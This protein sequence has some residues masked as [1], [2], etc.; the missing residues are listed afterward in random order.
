M[1]TFKFTWRR[2]NFEYIIL[3]LYVCSQINRFWF[4]HKCFPLDEHIT[5]IFNRIFH[6]LYCV[7]LQNIFDISFVL[8]IPCFSSSN[9]LIIVFLIYYMLGCSNTKV[10][11]FLRL[12]WLT[13]VT[14]AWNSLSPRKMT[15]KSFTVFWQILW[16]L[17]NASSHK[18][19]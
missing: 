6:F 9:F 4:V 12:F 15:F 3:K 14:F 11:V 8:K 17:S 10:I 1:H 5:C 19:G 16:M 7:I 2:L 18:N 13:G